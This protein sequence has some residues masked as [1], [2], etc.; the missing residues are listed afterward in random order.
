MRRQ[1]LKMMRRQ[2]LEVMVRSGGLVRGRGGVSRARERKCSDGTHLRRIR[3]RGFLG[4]VL[5]LWKGQR[6][7][8]SLLSE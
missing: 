1:V 5:G 6:M 4:D 8:S 7:M 2:G 3:W